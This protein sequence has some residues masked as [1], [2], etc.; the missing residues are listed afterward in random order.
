MANETISEQVKKILNL[1]EIVAILV[2]SFHFLLPI[3]GETFLDQ[4]EQQAMAGRFGSALNPPTRQ[5][6]HEK[7]PISVSK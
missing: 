6:A 7:I 3:G 5:R 1:E 4:T 2:R